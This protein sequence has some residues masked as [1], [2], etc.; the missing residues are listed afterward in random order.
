MEIPDRQFETIATR[1]AFIAFTIS[2][3]GACIYMAVIQSFLLSVHYSKQKVKAPTS[4][5][6]CFAITALWSF[7]RLLDSVI[8]LITSTFVLIMSPEE[9]VTEYYN[10]RRAPYNLKYW[11]GGAAESTFGW[12]GTVLLFNEVLVTWLV[13]QSLVLLLDT[14]I[15]IFRDIRQGNHQYIAVKLQTRAIELFNFTLNIYEKHNNKS[16]I[17]S[18]RSR[19]D[20]AWE[21]E[22]SNSQVIRLKRLQSDIP[23]KGQRTLNWDLT[24]DKNALDEMKETLGPPGGFGELGFNVASDRVCFGAMGIGTRFNLTFVLE[25]FGGEGLR[26]EK[27]RRSR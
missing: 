17:G 27:R 7:H 3:F 24:V 25:A 4:L 15:P 22:K 13:S 6:L 12:D 5:E 21:D 26:E 10:L 19:S 9:A 1:Y 16:S 8:G 20:G 18:G 14:I 23:D 2:S 11:A